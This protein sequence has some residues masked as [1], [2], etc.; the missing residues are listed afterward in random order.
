MKISLECGV[1]GI[2]SRVIAYLVKEFGLL[3]QGDEN[4]IEA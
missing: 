4:N 2:I 1:S 3:S